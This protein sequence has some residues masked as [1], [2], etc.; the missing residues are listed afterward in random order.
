MRLENYS[1]FLMNIPE[2]GHFMEV[3]QFVVDKIENSFYLHRMTVTLKGI[4]TQEL[5]DFYH[6]LITPRADEDALRMLLTRGVD[7]HE[8]KQ[9][10]PLTRE[11]LRYMQQFVFSPDDGTK[12]EIAKSIIGTLFSKNP[13]WGVTMYRL[14]SVDAI[15]NTTIPPFHRRFT[16][17]WDFYSPYYDMR[18][19][20]S[21]QTPM[22]YPNDVLVA[23]KIEPGKPKGAS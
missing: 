23:A 15:N 11:T 10:G 12:G 9:P 21:E 16:V 6:P 7:W 4:L 1:W 13:L 3:D 14:L 19:I 18:E 22:L 17:P 5:E 2:N 20:T 8:K